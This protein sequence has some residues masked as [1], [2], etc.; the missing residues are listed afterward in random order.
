MG[1]EVL[2][3]DHV[4]RDVTRRNRVVQSAVPV[5]RPAIERVQC[6]RRKK[7]KI[8]QIIAAKTI[9]LLR[10]NQISRPRARD[11]SLAGAH[12]DVGFTAVGV[13]CNAVVTDLTQRENELRRDNFK[14]L[15]GRQAPHPN[16]QNALRQLQLRTLVVE[17]EQRDSAI[18]VETDHGAAVLHFGTG[19]S[20]QPQTVTDA[21]RS[22]DRGLYPIIGPGR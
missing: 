5:G 12:D 6:W 9:A 10:I 15:L 17:I 2:V 1:I 20:V 3:T 4:A 19:T 22:I 14:H 18:G 21:Q 16:V 13:H 7:L 11:L 8:T